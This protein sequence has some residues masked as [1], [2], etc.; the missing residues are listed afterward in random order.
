MK[1]SPLL[2]FLSLLTRNSVRFGLMA[3]DL[4]K[5][6]PVTISV[7]ICAK[8]KITRVQIVQAYWCSVWLRSRCVPKRWQRNRRTYKRGLRGCGPPSP[9][10][11]SLSQSLHQA[12]P[13]QRSGSATRSKLNHCPASFLKQHIFWCK[14]RQCIF[15]TKIIVFCLKSC[16]LILIT[17]PWCRPRLLTSICRNILA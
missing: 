10:G 16:K 4:K 17:L 1:N 8:K 3:Q 15:V 9:A 12:R 11:P 14:V 13:H 5:S 2:V 7:F 6:P